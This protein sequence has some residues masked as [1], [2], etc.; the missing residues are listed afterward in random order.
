MFVRNIG[1]RISA[2]IVASLVMTAFLSGC[3]IFPK[4]DEA[5]APLL[6]ADEKITYKTI[7]AQKGT[8]ER[9]IKGTANFISAGQKELSFKYKGGRLKSLN[10]KPGDIVKEGELLAEL[11]TSDLENRIERQKAALEE[12]EEALKQLEASGKLDIESLKVQIGAAKEKYEKALKL[13]NVSPDEIKN[14]QNQERLLEI[15]LNKL[16]ANYGGDGKNDGYLI[17]QASLKVN[18]ERIS[19]DGLLKEYDES[20]LTSPISGTV[21]FVDDL[22]EGENVD[23]YHTVITVADPSKLLLQYIDD[24][25][26]Y[27]APGAEVEYTIDG[28]GYKGKI[29]STPLDI[30]KDIQSGNKADSKKNDSQDAKKTVLIKPDNLPSGVKIGDSAAIKYTIEKREN[31]IAIPNKLIKSFSGRRYVIVLK[32]GVKSERDLEVGVISDTDAEIVSGL[33]EGEDVI[34]D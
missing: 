7:K 27:F 11:D 16:Y 25:A 22:S 33:L 2:G 20:R 17:S 1:F 19:L 32:D 23:A 3:G 30:P 4:E 15:S 14:L 18:E 6:V 13:Q 5:L 34:D 10:I 21:V 12:Q 28:R 8:V 26:S 29:A 9:S 24:K 31:V